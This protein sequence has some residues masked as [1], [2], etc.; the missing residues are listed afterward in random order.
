MTQTA[1]F[2]N[3]ESLPNVSTQAILY[4]NSN[5]GTLTEVDLVT[6]G[7]FSAEF[8]A[9]NLGST[10]TTIN[11]TTSDNL[12]INVPSGAVPVT[13]PSVNWT[14][15]SGKDSAPVTSSS[16]PQTTELTSSA[17]LAAFTG[18]FRMPI[19]VS[20]QSTTS[21]AAGDGDL[22]AKFNTQTSA[23][24]TVIYHFTPNLP[25]LDP[26]PGPGPLSSTPT[27]STSPIS[28][29][30]TVTPL[31]SGTVQGTSTLPATGSTK[32]GLSS[33]HVQKNASVKKSTPIHPA[34]HH[35]L[36]RHPRPAVE[37]LPAKKAHVAH[38]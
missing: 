36:A 11:A 20:N 4:F 3:I 1:T 24:L 6:S 17:D 8:Q 22:S 12:S 31:P 15:N 5:M 13:I 21:S 2:P 28:G 9:E 32:I 27:S 18:N 26:P 37:H 23:T 10:A 38:T 29:S 7:S 35:V 33:G 16:T 30:S 14:L 25:S 19:S 34:V